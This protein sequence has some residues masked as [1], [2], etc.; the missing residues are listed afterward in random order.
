M[1]R[2]GQMV[3]SCQRNSLK[4]LSCEIFRLIKDA[5]VKIDTR[6]LHLFVIKIFSE[7]GNFPVL[8]FRRIVGGVYGVINQTQYR[9][10]S[11]A[12]HV[13]SIYRI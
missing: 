1:N 5:L 7:R 10:W 2:D 8:K 4:Q 11:G 12:R 9:A 13:R 3:I 6:F